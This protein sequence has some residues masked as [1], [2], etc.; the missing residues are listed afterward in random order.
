MS[1]CDAPTM[2]QT[3]I[4]SGSGVFLRIRLRLQESAMIQ[5]YRATFGATP[6]MISASTQTQVQGI[7]L[8]SGRRGH[9]R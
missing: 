3:P 8:Y 7:W 1:R 4:L 6:F 2:E 5:V 9:G